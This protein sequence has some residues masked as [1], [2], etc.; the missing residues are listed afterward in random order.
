M[1]I[2]LQ[3]DVSDILQ[4]LG[5]HAAEFFLAA[6]LYHARKISFMT[7]AQFA[8]LDFDGFKSRLIEHFDQGYIIADECILEDIKTINFNQ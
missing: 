2:E 4:P 5:N 7:A 1:H 8:G 6:S 3:P